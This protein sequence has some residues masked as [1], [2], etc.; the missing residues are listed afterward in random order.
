V[1]LARRPRALTLDLDDT[2]WPVWPAI[3]RAE[4][5]L[6]DWLKAHAPATAAA[7]DT[8]ALRA[9]REAVGREHP[10]QAHDLSWLRQ[11]SIARAL[12]HSGEDPSLAEP[13]FALFM[14]HRQR[15]DLFPEVAEALARLSA[16]F[17]VLALTNGNADLGRIGLGH[18]FVGTLGARS[19]GLG[20]PHAA[21]FHAA[22]ARLGCA[23]DEVL[24]IGDD[25]ALDIEGPT[26]PACTAPGSAGLR[27]RSRR[28]G[29]KPAPGGWWP[30]SPRWPTHWMPCRA[31][32]GQAAPIGAEGGI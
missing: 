6:H 14:D 27:G 31:E 9:V 29:R 32:R 2:L 24:H 8:A 3:E 17:P 18:H 25:W 22:C 20:K 21:F 10:E 11:T 28:R 30:T 13:A 19:F 23:P 4:A 26:A 1:S 5:V 12:A 15:V 7:F 16:G